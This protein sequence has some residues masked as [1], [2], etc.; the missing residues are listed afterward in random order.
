MKEVRNTQFSSD[1]HTGRD[2]MSD[3]VLDGLVVLK[4][5]LQKYCTWYG[6]NSAGSG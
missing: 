6:L 2:L 5:I 4:L 1:N 3:L